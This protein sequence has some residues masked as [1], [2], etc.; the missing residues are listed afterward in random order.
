MPIFSTSQPSIRARLLPRFPAQVLAGTGITITK[1][2]GTYVFAT[3][4]IAELP[5]SSLQSMPSGTLVGRD[6]GI[7]GG[8]P[9]VISVS[10]GLLFTGTGGI[11]LATNQRMRSLNALF[12]AVVANAAQD[13]SVAV[14]CTIRRV[15]LLANPS[16]N[17]T[18]DIWKTTFAGYPPTAVNSICPGPAKPIINAGSKLENTTL[19]G[20]TTNVLAGDTLRVVIESVT[21]ITRLTV[22]LDA[23][24]I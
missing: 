4:A 16:G 5:L 14:A 9:S 8:P 10:G 21:T 1:S 15:T 2:G 23:E 3:T 17:V 11:G 12:P 18:V 22:V 24:V 6:T 7:G 13:F 20:W 19:T